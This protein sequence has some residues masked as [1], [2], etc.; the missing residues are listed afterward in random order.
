MCDG[1]SDLCAL[2]LSDQSLTVL[3]CNMIRTVFEL[4][5]KKI[6]SC[7]VK[8]LERLVKLQRIPTLLTVDRHPFGTIYEAWRG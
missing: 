1:L 5:Y 6:E 2:C 8:A 3:A 7:R 4:T